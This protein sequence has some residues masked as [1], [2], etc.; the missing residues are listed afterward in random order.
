MPSPATENHDGLSDLDDLPSQW[1]DQWEAE[2]QAAESVSNSPTRKEF[3]EPAQEIPPAKA[4]ETKLAAHEK[5]EDGA[6][7]PVE[8]TPTTDVP[9]PSTLDLAVQPPADLA[10]EL[11][12]EVPAAEPASISPKQPVASASD[13]TTPIEAPQ[14]DLA[15]EWEAE[16]PAAQPLSNSPQQN[17]SE[18]PVQE[19]SAPEAAEADPATHE[20]AEVE[21]SKGVDNAPAPEVLEAS[22]FDHTAQPAADVAA[23]WE[24]EI[25]AAQP[26]SNSPPQNESEEPVQETSTTEDA[27]ADPATH[28]KAE[29]EASK[30]G[31]NAPISEGLEASNFD[32]TAQPSADLAAEWEAEFQA[33]ESVSNL[34]TRKE[35]EEAAQE[36]S[37][38][39]AADADLA[40]HKKDEVEPSK[41]VHNAPTPEVVESSTF[42]HTAQPSADLAAQWEAEFQALESAS[43]EPAFDEFD[44]LMQNTSTKQNPNAPDAPEAS[45]TSKPPAD[46]ESK[47]ETLSLDDELLDDELLPDDDFL[48]E[49]P[50]TQ[51]NNVHPAGGRTSAY[52]P[53]A[54]N[55][56]GNLMGGQTS[57]Y[58]PAAQSN[59][60]P[61]YG[62]APA[63][64]PTVPSFGNKAS[65]GPPVAEAPKAQSFVDKS[66][67]GYSS[68]YDLPP[69]LT[70]PKKRPIRSAARTDYRSGS[71]ESSVSANSMPGPPMPPMPGPPV[72][73]GSMQNP[74][75]PQ[76]APVGGPPKPQ[77]FVTKPTTG[78]SSPYDL[79]M[80]LTKPKPRPASRSYTPT[81]DTVRRPPSVDNSMPPPRRIENPYVRPASVEHTRFPPRSA[82]P[83]ARPASVENTPLPYRPSDPY[84]RPASVEHSRVPPRAHFAPPVIPEAPEPMFRARGYSVTREYIMPT[85][86]REQDPLKR[87]KGGPIFAWGAAGTVVTSFPREVPRYAVGSTAPKI[88]ISPGEISIR[89]M[90]DIY[91]ITGPVA[92]F[93]GPLRGKS[94][95]KDVL[96]WLSAGIV[97]LEREQFSQPSEG[98]HFDKR[99]EERLLLW[100]VLRALVQSDGILEG[101]AEVDKVVRSI[102]LPSDNQ[103]QQQNEPISATNGAIGDAVNPGAIDDIRKHLLQGDREKAVWSAVDN[104]LWAHAMLIAHTLP[105]EVYKQVAQEFVS[106]EVKEAGQHNK[107]LAA[108]YEV[109]AGN[110]TDSIDELVPPS[111]RAGLQMLRVSGGGPSHSSLSGLESWQE[112]LALILGNRSTG[113]NEAIHSLGKL[114]ASYGRT[115]A[116]HIC[117]IF[118]RSN[119]VFAGADDPNADMVLV[120]S[121]HRSA[122]HDFERDLES[123]QLTEVYEF[124]L[125]LSGASSM[126]IGTPHLTA[127]KLQ[128]AKFFSSRGLRAKAID[129]CDAISSMITSQTKRSPY[130]NPALLSELENLTKR[131]K[132]SPNE[133]RSSAWLAKPKMDKV[134]SSVWTTFNKFVAGDDEEEPANAGGDGAQ[135]GPFGRV[136]GGTPTIS[137]APTADIYHPQNQGL[138]MP[139]IGSLSISG[140]ASSFYPQAGSASSSYN[141]P[142]QLLPPF[143][144]PYVPQ[145]GDRRGSLGLQPA[146]YKRRQPTPDH[147]LRAVSRGSQGSR[148]APAPQAGY[149]REMSASPALNPNARY[150]PSPGPRLSEEFSASPEHIPQPQRARSYEPNPPTS[151]APVAQPHYAPGVN[152]NEMPNQNA[153]PNPYGNTDSN[154]YD[155]GRFS[156]NDGAPH[157]PLFSENRSQA[158]RMPSFGEEESSASSQDQHPDNSGA[159]QAFNQPNAF[160][161]HET[162]PSAVN[163]QNPT[164]SPQQYGGYEP[165]SSNTFTPH[166]SGNGGYEPPA[167]NTYT[168]YDSGSG[169]YTPPTF[170]PYVPE[171]EP[172]SPEE[173]KPKRS[174][175]DDD[176]DDFVGKSRAPKEKTKEEKDREADE[177]FR[178]AAEEDAKRAEAE[179]SQKK[180]GWGL[181]SWFKK[182]DSIDN[183]NANAQ[184]QGQPNKPIKAKLG[185]ESSFYYDKELKRWVNSKGDKDGPAKSATPPPPKGPPRISTAPP[186]TR[187]G[188]FRTG[189]APPM[190]TSENLRGLQPSSLSYSSRPG[191]SDGGRLDTPPPPAQRSGSGLSARSN[192]GVTPDVVVNPPPAGSGGP[193]PPSRSAGPPK[194]ANGGMNIDDLLGPP[195]ARKRGAIKKKKSSRYVD[196]MGQ[197]TNE[198]EG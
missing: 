156:S 172:E 126:S 7:K 179:K 49:A 130:H 157:A 31:D 152:N 165:P 28:E 143:S 52:V 98:L 68:P 56:V 182:K 180:G 29:F 91:P 83:Y 95:K 63:F 81:N 62:Y 74:P 133:E 42:D 104:R 145:V 194:P 168:P 187:D 193:P 195:Q 107:S 86:G 71:M 184:G 96:S 17:E 64:T 122:T 105:A 137:R 158:D 41:A 23:E 27:E 177:A 181:G 171:P 39:E 14:T 10:E 192:D 38:P 113:D 13:D 43:N 153:H 26:V 123:I 46:I 110:H 170:E 35:F 116:A 3:E 97:E 78:Y 121:D 135:S 51:N 58:T 16:V 163:A 144:P 149:S 188:Q 101:N 108:L 146:S 114:L 185:E 159:A 5:A 119:A 118:G 109:F 87:W 154:S 22:T 77:S 169:G 84:A 136:S 106:K 30:A 37:T 47:W 190:K 36:T 160:V 128:L 59:Q 139:D 53:V 186:A 66:I 183:S 141:P 173:K 102:I 21:A 24:A 189:S 20:K 82:V 151:Y 18:E 131:L 127:Y 55:N 196:V 176:D 115:E 80:D 191:T 19:T 155:R 2:L 1:E 138:G 76:A 60:K 85:D 150:A 6:S 34:P 73:S 198:T 12:A 132:Q 45:G 88:Q 67:G 79:P 50:T 4:I 92:D 44:A 120:G 103:N 40:T 167:A 129:Y 134:S 99:K 90:K 11:K 8:N 61:T 32:D 117:F 166:D 89:N 148:Y 9:E 100:K 69:D 175:M 94:K 147:G 54:Q 25:P 112:T 57:S 161:S 125:S 65:S 140:G 15:A 142:S 178:K 70:R 124:A 33:A 75:R 197:K 162:T 164:D 93:P 174:F 72:R 111:A 48:P